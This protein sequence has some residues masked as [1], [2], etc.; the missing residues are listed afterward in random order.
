MGIFFQKKAEVGET[1]RIIGNVRSILR[2]ATEFKNYTDKKGFDPMD[3]E[4]LDKWDDRARQ[5]LDPGQMEEFLAQVW[6]YPVLTEDYD[7]QAELIRARDYVLLG[8][9]FTDFSHT[10]QSRDSNRWL[11]N[12][13]NND[14]PKMMARMDDGS[15]CFYLPYIADIGEGAFIPLEGEGRYASKTVASLAQRLLKALLI[16]GERLHVCLAA[17][18]S[19]KEIP[20]FEWLRN[21]LPGMDVSVIS[22]SM[23]E[24]VI[25]DAVNGLGDKDST[26]ILGQSTFRGTN[27][28][29]L[30]LKA[31]MKGKLARGGSRLYVIGSFRES[32]DESCFSLCEG[33]VWERIHLMD[34]RSNDNYTAD[35][36]IPFRLAPQL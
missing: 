12:L 29:D 20:E 21:G 19:G 4:F 27:L 34:E 14:Y 32:P 16:R 8:A 9:M 2:T 36:L 24:R 6:K 26:V 7:R 17:D 13:M 30:L 18:N 5:I 25:T 35:E 10:E 28:Y 22:V 1:D 3:L 15:F 23:A 11:M 33:S 31:R